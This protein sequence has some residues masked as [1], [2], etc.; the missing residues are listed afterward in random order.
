MTREM[1][2]SSESTV[3]EFGTFTTYGESHLGSG[4]QR[5][6]AYT[7]ILHDLGDEVAGAEVVTDGH[8]DWRAGRGHV[9]REE[10]G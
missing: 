7:I 9:G 4:G 6:T 1:G 2:M 3:I 10:G 8:A 5:A